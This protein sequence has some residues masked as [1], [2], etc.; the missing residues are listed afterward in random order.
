MHEF[1]RKYHTIFLIFPS[2]IPLKVKTYMIKWTSSS[3]I[4]RQI[5]LIEAMIL[6]C[7]IRKNPGN[8]KLQVKGCYFRKKFVSH[9]VTLSGINI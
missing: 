6:K 1:R 8:K 9:S 5:I 7:E 4:F 2:L 3:D